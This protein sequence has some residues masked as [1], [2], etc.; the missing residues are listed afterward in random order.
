MNGH[1]IA[2]EVRVEPATDKRMYLDR[3]SLDQHR[4]ERLDAHP[5]E[6]RGAVQENR[7]LVD[8]FL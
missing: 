2:V 1:L 8:D 5:V 6:R 3:V 7:V 4:L